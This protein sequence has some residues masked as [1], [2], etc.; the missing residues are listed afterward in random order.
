MKPTS[1]LG[2]SIPAKCL[3]PPGAVVFSRLFLCSALFSSLLSSL[4]CS[5]L[6]S[7][8]LCSPLFSLALCRLLR[9]SI[10]IFLLLRL[11]LLLRPPML[12]AKKV[13]F[14]KDSLDLAVANEGEPEGPVLDEDLLLR[15]LLAVPD[16]GLL[17]LGEHN[18]GLQVDVGPADE[19]KILGLAVA[20]LAH[21]AAVPQLN[22]ATLPPRLV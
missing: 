16:L 5:L 3:V 2:V 4:L 13:T 8:V 17:P 9:C 15:L 21:L 19:G 11:L 18:A 12:D 22:G 1:G 20:L 6:C 10:L 14:V 7:L